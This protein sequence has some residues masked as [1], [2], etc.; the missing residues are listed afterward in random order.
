MKI[1]RVLSAALACAMVM[2]CM[3][4]TSGC[5]KG[6]D[7]G[8]NGEKKTIT[9]LRSGSLLET[10]KKVIE[11]M[12]K[13]YGITVEPIICTYGE[14]Q[15]KIVT[16]IAAKDPL[17]VATLSVN[18]FP[19]FAKQKWTQPL[20]E[21]VNL[22]SDQ[23]SKSVM[24]NLFSYKG[25]IYCAT[26]LKSVSPYVLF[27]NKDLFELEGLPDPMTYYKEGKWNWD[28]FKQICA[29]FTTDTDGDSVIDR[30]GYAGWYRDCFYGLNHCSPVKVDDNGNY[31][32]NLKDPKVIRSLEMMRD[33]WHVYKYSGI[34]GN[35]IYE[36]FYQGK[37]AFLNEYCWAERTIIKAQKDGT[38]DFEYG[39]VPAPYGPDNKEK[40]NLVHAGGFSIVNGSKA[41]HNAGKFIEELIA[42]NNHDIAEG[43]KEI[44][45]EH[46]KLYDE[47]RQKGYTDRT[48]DNVIDYASNL[49]GAV[50]GG[51]DIQSAIAEW[52][53]QFQRKLDEA[54]QE[55]ETPVVKEFKTIDL[56]FET[57][58]KSLIVNPKKADTEG[59][60]V[61]WVSG[62][63][64]IDGN[65]SIR[66][67]VTPD[68]N[69]GDKVDAAITGSG[70]TVLP[71]HNY[72][73]KFSYKVDKL[74]GKYYVGILDTAKKKYEMITFEPKEAGTVC[75][76]ES[77]YSAIGTNTDSLV[78]LFTCEG[79][80]P[81][82][83]DNFVV[84][85]IKSE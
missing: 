74:G 50:T 22:D 7:K 67:N 11:L 59:L 30:W 55:P 12:K 63:D 23:M 40:I 60:S 42:M 3:A 81:I 68:T 76:F 41:P 43:D 73:I 28:T 20:K 56:K 2:S 57:D 39:V 51:K 85:E 19:L 32:M 15:S 78:F 25:E 72:N 21:Y 5:K 71:W 61:E 34:E 79:A 6:G 82:T 14:E 53:P 80:N 18:E 62:A 9:Y 10:D 52:E 64:A 46:V 77:K 48:F 75:K 65:G 26:A 16:S 35:D 8:E 49:N 29:I 31:V 84:E 58:D 37:N 36:S 83:I 38:C 17:D 66:I 33:M 45:E 27:Y 24:E 70:V 1:K 47:L 13:E 4:V 69:D 44:P 54:N